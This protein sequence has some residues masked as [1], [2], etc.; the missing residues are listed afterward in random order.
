MSMR[1]KGLITAAL[2]AAAVS[3]VFVVAAIPTAG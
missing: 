2:A 1:S 3:A